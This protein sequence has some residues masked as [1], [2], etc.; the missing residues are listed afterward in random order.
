MK[1]RVA[2]WGPRSSGKKNIHRSFCCSYSLTEKHSSSM[3]S[4]W[5]NSHGKQPLVFDEK[6]VAVICVW[7][8]LSLQASLQSFCV[9]FQW[10]LSYSEQLSPRGSALRLSSSFPVVASINGSSENLI[11][12]FYSLHLVVENGSPAL[13]LLLFVNKASAMDEE[14]LLMGCEVP[15]VG[16]SH[17]ISYSTTYPC[18]QWESL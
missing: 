12:F 3:L 1:T 18:W 17:C 16:E 10:H 13:W 7:A 9:W 14:S 6:K 15:A 8:G 4:H 2:N 5:L 11:K